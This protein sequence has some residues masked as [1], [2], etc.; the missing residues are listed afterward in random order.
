LLLA[1]LVLAA[2]AGDSSPRPAAVA[3]FV[4][5]NLIEV[6]V[7]DVRALES[8]LL[9]GPGGRS[10]EPADIVAGQPAP[11]PEAPRPGIGVF[12]EGG[13]SSG[14]TPGVVLGVPLRLGEGARR[15]PVLSSARFRLPD[16]E[17]YRRSWQDWRI[18]LRLG[19]PGAEAAYLTV[20]APA[21]KVN[22]LMLPQ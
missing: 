8:A 20:P 7:S 3:E 5:A 11:P 19:P 13:S 21:P 15:T 1:A 18:E 14:V 9:V 4:G 6:R 16:P 10:L 2:C 22:G 17:F 12:V